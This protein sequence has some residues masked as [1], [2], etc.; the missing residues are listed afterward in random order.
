MNIFTKTDIGLVRTENQDNVWGEML[1]E[2]ACAAVLCDG[3][4]GE[5]EGGLASKLAVDLI[6][7]RIKQN[8]SEK[9]SRNSVRNLLITSVVAANSVVLSLIHI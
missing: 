7:E 8:F 2:N 4:G 1:T 6:S 5:S 3:M 9:M